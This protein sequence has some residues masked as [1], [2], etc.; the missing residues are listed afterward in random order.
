MTVKAHVAEIKG[1]KTRSRGRNPFGDAGL[2]PGRV[3]PPHPLGPAMEYLTGPVLPERGHS[4][5]V[6]SDEHHA[7]SI[8]GVRP[9]DLCAFT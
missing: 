3:R 9:M 4:L 1:R 2:L 6:S 8:T 5:A 7:K